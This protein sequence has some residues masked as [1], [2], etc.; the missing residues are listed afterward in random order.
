MSGS[1]KFLPKRTVRRESSRR[2]ITPNARPVSAGR[3]DLLIEWANRTGT[4]MPSSRPCSNTAECMD[5]SDLNG[6]TANDIGSR[7][8]SV[9]VAPPSTANDVA[10][11][12]AA[13]A[14]RSRAWPANMDRVDGDDAV[15]D[16]RD[17]HVDNDGAVREMEAVARSRPAQEI[18]TAP[19]P[20]STRHS[21]PTGTS[22]MI[23]DVTRRTSMY[24]SCDEPS[25]SAA[26]NEIS[27]MPVPG[28][29]VR[30]LTA[31]SQ[32]AGTLDVDTLNSTR[33]TPAIAARRMSL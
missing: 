26:A 15:E 11:K 2:V 27:S 23:R 9:E 33:P 14:S 22:P 24:I 12:G 8:A 18:L 19:M 32:R 29:M 25:I 1:L 16:R 17:V 20:R 7:D 30:P 5:A 21:T 10:T 4:P 3:P 13:V 31:W 28:M 6:S